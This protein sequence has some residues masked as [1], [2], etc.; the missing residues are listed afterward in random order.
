[1]AEAAQARRRGHGEDSIYFDATK[2][3]YVGA[4][5]AGWGP[6]GTRLRRKVRGKTKQEVRDKLRTLHRE[7]D[8][9]VRSPG[10]YSLRQAV[11]DWIRD[12][13][14]GR[15]QRTCRLYEGLLEPVVDALGS[16]RLRELSAADVRATLGQLTSR[17]STR[18][19]QSR[20]MRWSGRSGMRRPT[21]WSA[22]MWPR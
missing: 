15:S 17:Y 19:L 4:V 21:I 20:I 12:G 1:M 16:K 3:R 9:G 6:D 14:D 8:A 2:N 13:L 11:E 7:L 18:S 10:R 22:G 5:S